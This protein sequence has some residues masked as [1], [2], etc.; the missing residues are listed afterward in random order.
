[1]AAD[2]FTLKSHSTGG[3]CDNV[4]MLEFR[5]IE[6]AQHE[7][8]FVSTIKNLVAKKVDLDKAKIPDDVYGAKRFA[9]ILKKL[10][11]HAESGCLTVS[12]WGKRSIVHPKSL[13]PSYLKMMHGKAHGGVHRTRKQL[14]CAWWP[15]QFSNI[16]EFV[17]FCS[18]CFKFKGHN[19]QK[20]RQ[21]RQVLYRAK[22][23]M[24]ILYIDFIKLPRLQT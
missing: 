24:E 4:P 12:W 5:I 18:T 23:S 20:E 11:I 6:Q 16:R 9:W 19:M 8:K 1:M 7:D 14:A 2:C 13:V 15:D 21:D 17:A 22:S 10:E 3:W